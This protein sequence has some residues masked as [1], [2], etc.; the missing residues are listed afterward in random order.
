MFPGNDYWFDFAFRPKSGEWPA[1]TAGLSDDE[2]LVMQTHP[3]L[4][5]HA[6]TD[7][8]IRP[9]RDA[10]DAM[11][12]IGSSAT[13]A[14][15]PQGQVTD[16]SMALPTVDVWHKYV[17]PISPG[18]LAGQKTKTGVWMSVGGG[19]KTQVVKSTGLNDYNWN[20]GTYPRIGSY[21]WVARIGRPVIR[22]LRPTHHALL[23][24]KG[25]RYNEAVAS[26]AGL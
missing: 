22:Q 14:M 19:A 15:T 3:S 16:H 4:R 20:T 21:K 12:E 23:G 24:P 17:V 13:Q 18:Y 2:F 8:A 26:L 11:A 1:P 9:N 10:G 5:R 6:A 25:R 7:R